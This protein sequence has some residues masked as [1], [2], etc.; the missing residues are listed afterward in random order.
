MTTPVP[1]PGGCLSVAMAATGSQISV[2]TIF[3]VASQKP[4]SSLVSIELTMAQRTTAPPTAR[5]K[6]AAT[7]TATRVISPR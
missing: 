1:A 5:N 4:R 7:P 3:F 2:P 6:M